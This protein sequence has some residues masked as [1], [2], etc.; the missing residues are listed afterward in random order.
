MAKFIFKEANHFVGNVTFQIAGDTLSM[1]FEQTP[2]GQDVV[3]VEKKEDS[4]VWG[5]M[6]REAFQEALAKKAEESE[7]VE[8][9]VTDETE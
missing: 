4:T 5:I 1:G 8:S 3:I 6:T 7:L 2:D 9:E